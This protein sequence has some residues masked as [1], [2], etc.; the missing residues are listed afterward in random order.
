MEETTAEILRRFQESWELTEERFANLIDLNP[1]FERLI[2]VY[3]FIQK[4]K[5]AGNNQF[6]RLGTSMHELIISRSVNHGLRDDQK[7]IRI[8]AFDDSFEVTLKDGNKMYRQYKIE[9]LGD[10]RLTGLLETLKSTLID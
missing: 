3:L 6:F 9:E 1:G 5:D 4:L 8:E 2:P 7:S 10:P